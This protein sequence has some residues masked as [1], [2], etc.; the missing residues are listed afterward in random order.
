MNEQDA[1]RLA[2]WAVGAIVDR[3]RSEGGV[4]T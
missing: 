1:A 3:A 4:I 2:A